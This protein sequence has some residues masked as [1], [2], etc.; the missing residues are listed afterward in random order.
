MENWQQI[1]TSA[2][3]DAVPND[4]SL[5]VQAD[6][7]GDRQKSMGGTSGGNTSWQ[8]SYYPRA[9]TEIAGIDPHR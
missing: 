2:K 9:Q 7:T 6:E 5:H 3:H 8:Q 4:E 1:A